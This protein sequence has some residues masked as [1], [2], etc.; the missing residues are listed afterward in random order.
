[1]Q[2]SYVQLVSID[3]DFVRDHERNLRSTML[4]VEKSNRSLASLVSCSW[5]KVGKTTS[6][7]QQKDQ[8]KIVQIGARRRR[9]LIATATTK[10]ENASG[11]VAA[12]HAGATCNGRAACHVLSLTVDSPW[13]TIVSPSWR[14][15]DE[16]STLTDQLK[17]RHDTA[18][19]QY[20]VQNQH[21]S[22]PAPPGRAVPGARPPGHHRSTLAC[23]MHFE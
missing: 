22:S 9:L 14:F 7:P 23:I 12:S 10:S 1:M 4:P 15:K 20:P 3:T 11:G 18:V 8:A 17:Y 16:S 19:T 5:I 21:Q 2:L 6:P 13:H